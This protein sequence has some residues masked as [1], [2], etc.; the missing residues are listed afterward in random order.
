MAQVELGAS[1]FAHDIKAYLERQKSGWIERMKKQLLLVHI[2]AYVLQPQHRKDWH[3]FLLVSRKQVM[4]FLND[5][6][7]DD[8]QNQFFDYINQVRAFHSRNRC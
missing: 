4:D 2:L 5:Y 1:P 7:D 8:L 3:T 6:G